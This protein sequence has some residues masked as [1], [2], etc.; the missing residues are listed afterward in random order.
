MNAT[1]HYMKKLRNYAKD[2]PYSIEPY[3]KMQELLDLI[4]L[5]LTQ[6]VDAKDYDPGFLQWDSMLTYWFMLK[7]PIPKEK[8][9]ATAKLYFNVCTTPGM[10]N[11]VV[12]AGCDA[13]YLLT[14]S[15]NK[16]SIWD[17]RFPW[18]P[19][20]NILSKDL[21]MTR[22]QFEISQTSWYMGYIAENIQRFFHPVAIDEMLSTFL[23]MMK[24]TSLSTILASQYY[25]LT[26]LPMSHPQSYLPMMFRLWESVNSYMFD[27]HMLQFFANLA[28]MHVDPTVSD[29]LRIEEIPDDAR[30]E[31]E[32]RPKWDKRDLENKWKWS[33]LYSDVG[34]FTEHDWNFIVTKCLASME[35]P[36]A[37]AGSLTTGPNADNQASFE[38]NRLPKPSGRISSLARI[39]VYSMAQDGMSS[40]GSTTPTPAFTPLTSR[41]STPLPQH[42]GGGLSDYLSASLAK[43]VYSKAKT[44]LAGCRALDSLVK[45]IAST[46]GFFH[47]TNSGTWTSDLSAFIKHIVYEF[48]KR[49]YEEQ[50]PDC[51]TPLHRRLTRDMKRELVKSLRTVALLAMFSPDNSTVSNIQSCLKSMSIMEPDLILHPVLERA[52]PALETLVET[53]RTIA[54]IK[55]LGAVAP[56][57]VCRHVYYAGAKHLLPILELLLPGIDLFCTTAFIVEIAQYIKFG[58]MTSEESNKPID[59][60]MG[61]ATA[62]APSLDVTAFPQG[63][64]SSEDVQLTKDEEDA[65]LKNMSTTFADWVAAFLRR[66]ILLFENLPEEGADGTAG[67]A[68]EVQLV[69]AVCGAFSQI[70]VHLSQPLYDMVLNMVFDYASEN[71]RSNA[72]R[73]IHQLVECIANA[74]PAKTLAKFVPFCDR[75]IRIE[76]EHGASSLRTTSPSSTPLPSDATLH[77][78]LAILRG[79]MY[80]DGRAAL[81]YRQDLIALFKLL[82]EKTL[83]KRGF[84]NTGKLLSSTLLTL[85]HTY[86]LE[87]K[88]VNPDEWASEEF[89]RNHH[90]YWGKLYKP[91]DVKLSWHVPNDEETDFALEI[92]RKVVEPTLT[93]LE[94][95]LEP[96]VV[97]DAVWRNDFC[98]HLSFVRN[99]FSGIPTFAKEFIPPADMRRGIET[100]DIIHELPEMIAS[101][102]PLNAGFALQDLSDPRHQYITS[103]KQRFG[104]FLHSASESL[105]QQGE[106]NT[107]DAVHMLIRSI[108]TYMLDYGDNRDNYFLQSDRYSSEQNVA[109]HYAKQ[110]VWPRALYVRRARFY[111][112]ARLR[113]NSIER[114][115]GPL[116]D[117]LIDDI[118]E[119]AMWHYVTDRTS[120]ALLEDLCSSFDG[121]RRRC[122][123]KLY[124]ALEPGT[125]DD[126]MKGALWTLNCSAFA[127]YAIGEPILT[128]ELVKR[129]FACQHNE[130]PSIQDYVASLSDTCLNGFN[131]PCFVVY[132]IEN[133]GL[134]QAIADMK[135]V[136][137]ASHDDSAMVERCRDQR[138]SRLSLANDAI[139]DTTNALLEIAE[140]PRT[141]WRYAIVAIR[142]LRTLVRRDI[143]VQAPH[144]RY[145][146]E[147]TLDSHSSIYAQRAIMKISRYIKLRTLSNGPIDL[148]LEQNHNPL[149][150]TVS[151]AKPTH[152]FTAEWLAELRRPINIERARREPLIRDKLSSGWL[153][154]KAT[155]DCF[156]APD[157]VLSTFKPWNADCEEAFE[158]ICTIVT[159]P[160]YWKK[161]AIHYAAENHTDVVSQDNAS[162]VKSIFQLLEY[163]PFE[164][165]RPT[166]E[167]LIAN[168]DKNKQRAAA[169]F[170]AGI[171]A[172]SKHWPT[173]SQAKLWEWFKPQMQS[174]FAHKSNDTLPVW[175]SFVEYVFFNRDPRR[176]QPLV[177][178]I[179]AE[180]EDVDF[181][182]ES[183]S[184]VVHVLSIF[185]AF[186]EELGWKFTPW[187][188]DAVER[189]WSELSRTEHDDVLAYISEIMTYSGKVMWAPR[190]STPTADVFVRECRILPLDFDIMGVRGTFH[191]G[192]I[193][194]LVE[195]FKAWRGQRLPG[196]RAFQSTYDRV[197]VLVCKWLFQMVHDVNA[198]A[199][200][201]YI[202][203][204]MP[205][206]F[207]FAEVN[208]NDD[209]AHRAHLLLVRMCG[210]VP[211]RPLIYPMLD[212]IFVAIQT[213]PSWRVRLKVLPLVQVFYFRQ[214]PLIS[215]VKIVE[216]IEVVCR[217]LDDEVVEVREM[218][219]T[220]LSGILRLSPRRSV[221][222]LRDR[223]VRLL[224]NSKLPGRRSPTY[225]SALRQRHAAILGICA[226][227]D[228]YPYTVE[229]WLPDLLTNVLAEHTYDPI[230]ISTTVRKCASNF[231]KTHQDTWHE[232]CKRFTDSQLTALSTL[233][234]GSSYCEC[235]MKRIDVAT[236]NSDA[237]QMRE[238]ICCMKPLL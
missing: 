26:F 126:R 46:E 189:C 133:T 168:E 234:T 76:L 124:K 185:R 144:A 112:S 47:P 193:L 20:F 180:F 229:R 94:G 160:S 2:L 79:S 186:Y 69:D 96:G 223:F 95:L 183:T 162:C 238:S 156:L 7:Y 136:L 132:D 11:H 105:R 159:D 53:Q 90:Q 40:P 235:L 146:V 227:V 148:A 22:R 202:L 134:R 1:D 142:C 43:G 178:Y 113:W 197:G 176:L 80:N 10:P 29:P 173:N 203:P 216:M 6:C 215:D 19:I 217:C 51:K 4:L 122:L 175:T 219:A 220:T 119:W 41:S 211:P 116:E 111:H 57:L 23:P 100:T 15:K 155:A 3:L 214:F 87:N 201:D 73:A 213:S 108:R 172:G 14:R 230:P 117:K 129:L 181:N 233:L 222:H 37:D 42:N 9:I 228:S 187:V 121:I 141:H 68:T 147:K 157:A 149:R 115:R 49:W 48:N 110:K 77:W 82:H 206:L 127:K 165:L 93:T 38:L 31:G 191:E 99:A 123:P 143:A 25:M 170:L 109:R 174:I 195:K 139:A 36:L 167:E 125:E 225:T 75:N 66:V 166:L 224:K 194:D 34:I 17:M 92:F 137:A 221:L 210:V 35:I 171:F 237:T 128:T 163:E 13:L 55:A 114:R 33:G 200:F 130:R 63:I 198:I 226:L 67:G 58:E 70:C 91:E 151:I 179:V 18:K 83:S 72:V 39:I 209:L 184:E 145:L 98:R 27:D 205:E 196:S 85:T 50:Q 103:L 104:E 182:N 218:A 86:P 78:N 140:S 62:D 21:F 106:E 81:P 61:R 131:E 232:D 169:E 204:L 12:A 199:A 89:R 54:V 120:Q 59:V 24:G 164:A 64:E 71:V 150:R 161:L 190:P 107:V 44:Y 56:A 88:L 101:I 153:V 16:L 74:D 60:D 84:S 212:A 138:I 8:R 188:D 158:A 45:L 118:T 65:I 236:L 231:K 97:R 28:E 207:R 152:E 177:D 52:V 102:E 5:R 30:S 154:W 135:A 192:R 208:D 32:G